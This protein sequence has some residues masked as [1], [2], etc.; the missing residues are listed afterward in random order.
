MRRP[1]A[2]FQRCC[3]RREE[4]EDVMEGVVR[5]RADAIAASIR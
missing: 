2:D 5:E 4:R 3:Q 1:V